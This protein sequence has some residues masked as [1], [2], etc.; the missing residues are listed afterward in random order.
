MLRS[1]RPAGNLADELM[2]HACFSTAVP[3]VN[4]ELK[5]YNNYYS[6]S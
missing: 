2:V 4:T 3:T 5:S 6:L 1:D